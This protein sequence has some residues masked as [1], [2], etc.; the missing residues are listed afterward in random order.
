M[1]IISIEIINVKTEF[2][3]D[4]STWQPVV[5]KI[6]TDEGIS[7]YGEVGLA[8]GRGYTAG[9]GMVKDLAPMIIG[10]DPRQTEKIW[11]TFLKKTF[12]GQ[13]GG[14]IIF[15]GISAIDMA[16]WDIQGKELGVPIYRLLG[17]KTRNKIRAY[18]SQLQ[19]GWG[20]GKD[21]Q[22]LNKPEE[23]VQVALQAAEEGYDA[24]KVDP[25]GFD[26]DGKWRNIELAGVV[27]QDH[28]NLAYE[29]VKAIR[30]AVGSE[31][32]IIVELHAMTDTTSAIQLGRKLKDLNIMYYEEPTMPL[33]PELFKLIADNVPIPLAAGERIYS[34]W[35]YRPFF[36][37]GSLRIIQP[38]LG[39]CGG[40]TEGKKI[41]DMAHVYDVRVQPHICGGPIATAAALQLEA[42]IPNFIIHETH[43]FSLLE[44]NIVTCKYDYQP[45][46][47]YYEVPER[48][49]IGQELTDE[50]MAVSYI[51]K[52]Q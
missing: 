32:D 48:P 49:G 13:G 16:L 30:D 34:R 42:V 28:I 38:D 43:R 1:K 3:P 44:G 24:I 51:E 15:A 19:F 8:Y 47:G 45:Q 27:P 22:S 36:E 21:K 40:I 33:N 50:I 17:G 41:C 46:N 5:V 23:Y 7:G 31:V 6:N 2:A 25:V 29:R 35:G 4:T 10:K 37:N 39:T 52:I 26:K 9:F 14:T 18:A 12:W 11:E 20:S